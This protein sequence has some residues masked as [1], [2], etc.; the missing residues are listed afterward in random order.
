MGR[1]LSFL[2]FLQFLFQTIQDLVYLPA[3]A[4]PNSEPF[5]AGGRFLA[6]VISRFAVSETSCGIIDRSKLGLIAGGDL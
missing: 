2:F 6:S 1:A 4:K 3:P 5:I